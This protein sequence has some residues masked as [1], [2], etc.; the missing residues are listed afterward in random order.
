MIATDSLMIAT[1][2]MSIV[3]MILSCMA[4]WPQCKDGLVVVRDRVLWI[5]LVAVVVGGA[6][7]A[8]RVQS[9][10]GLGGSMLDPPVSDQSLD[11]VD[12]STPS[13][14][15]DGTQQARMGR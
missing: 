15:M 3:S 12:W 7:L 8:W 2:I 1:L 9:R 6:T 14:T 11:Y 10:V 13:P 4:L 5:A